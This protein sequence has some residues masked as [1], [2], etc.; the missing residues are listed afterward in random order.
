MALQEALIKAMNEFG[1]DI[2]IEPR[3]L[4][5]LN[6][7]HGF[8]DLRSARVI[9]KS[10]QNEHV[11]N[12]LISGEHLSEFKVNQV[13]FKLNDLYGL[14]TSLTETIISIIQSAISNTSFISTEATPNDMADAW[15]DED[16]ILYSRD[17]H[18]LL[19]AK[20]T[21]ITRCFVRP[22]TRIICDKGFKGC[23]SL[24]FVSFPN[25]LTHIGAFAFLFCNSLE[26]IR[27]PDSLTSIGDFAFYYC[28]NIKT[29]SLPQGLNQIGLN[30]FVNCTQLREVV[31][32]S[33]EFM[34]QNYEL[35]NRDKSKLI[36]YFGS[37]RSICLTDGLIQIGDYAFVDKFQ[38]YSIVLP[39]SLIRIGHS[40]FASCERLKTILLPNSITHIGHNAFCKCKSL[41]SI[42]LPHSLT[43]IG[44]Y[45]FSESG[46]VTIIIPPQTTR[47]GCN[48]FLLCKDLREITSL[49]SEF[50]IYGYGLYSSDRSKLISYFGSERSICLS[51]GLTQIGDSAFQYCQSLHSII[52]P[53]GLTLIGKN[54]FDECCE[55]QYISLPKSLI[56]ISEQA[57]LNC[58]SLQSIFLPT[59]LKYIGDEAFSGCDLQSITMPVQLMFWG[60]DALDLDLDYTIAVPKGSLAHYV[61]LLPHELHEKLV[62]L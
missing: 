46:I 38:L 48:P 36:S 37:D 16:G 31:S 50:S 28:R 59:D 21:T 42:E 9:L 57:F 53:E 56:K 25:S 33:S 45:A 1:K 55:L 34:I 44:D 23:Q 41:N 4:N 27:L 29:I 22:G 35:Y 30:P 62:E 24:R 39:D 8:E 20:N 12:T 2:L 26:G 19:K 54:A 32:L 3:L 51:K 43:D 6:D 49:S 60:N 17:G 47:I 7:Y 10:L 58:E 14:D 61:R 5:I 11:M 15:E 18:K 13:T 52:L 40:A